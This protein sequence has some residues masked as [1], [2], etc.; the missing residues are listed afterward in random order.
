MK[1]LDFK[2][3]DGRNIYSHK[4]CIRMDLD[5]EGYSEIPSKDIN[6]FNK[7][8]VKI[9]PELKNH[10]CGDNEENGF[11]K[12][13]D[14]GTYLAHIC[15]HVTIAVQNMIGINVSYG[16]AREVFGD[17]YYIIYQFQYKNVGIEAGKTAVDIINSII[18]QKKF[19]MKTRIN[20]L[21][22]VL[23]NEMIG[24]STLSIINEAKKRGI[25]VTK[26]GDGS[27]FQLGYG[28]YSKIIEATITEDTSTVAVDIAC[29][30]VLC[31]E[32]LKRQ[33]LPVARG[34]KVNNTLDLLFKAD[35]I[36]YPVVLKPQFGNQG[37]GVF[38]NLNNEKAVV[39]AYCILSKKYNDIIIEKYI[40]G[41]DF[42]VC[43]IDGEVAAV[44]ERIPPFVIGNGINTIEELIECINRSPKRGEGHEK[45]LTKISIDEGLLSYIKKQ[46]YCLN[47]VL[48]DGTK[49]ILREN[50]NLSTGGSAVDCTELICEENIEICRRAAKAIGLNI[51]GIDIC[52]TD[53]S[54]PISDNGAIIEVNAAPG[55]RMHQFPSKG[56]TRDTASA[57]V[58]MLFKSEKNSV[59]VISISGTNGKTTTSRLIAHVL[60][61]AGYN[62]GMT[63]TG[64]IYINNK[65][66]QRGDTTGPMSALTVLTNKE[67]DAAVLETARGGIIR[68]GL[69]YDLADV[70][71]ITNITEDHLGIDGIENIED[72]A[73]VKALVAEA[74]KDQGYV[75]INADDRMSLSILNRIKSKIIFFTKDKNNVFLRESLK[76][77]GYGVYLEN[78]SIV[79]Q[80]KNEI[81]P[82]IKVDK[83]G[84][85]LG[86]KLI[87]N[88]ENAMAACASLIALGIDYSII[89]KGL[90][91]FSCNEECNPGRF[92]IYKFNNITVV[93]DYGHNIEGYRAVLEGIKTLKHK[94]LVG[95]IGV[96]GDRSDRSIIEIG[97]ISAKYFDYI[98]IKEDKDRRGRK[99]GEVAKLLER[100]ALS[101]DFH[102]KSIDIILSEK[103]AL[104]KAINV[105]KSGDIIII[106][107]ENYDEL[108]NIVK[109]KINEEVKTISDESMA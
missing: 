28:R 13:L 52:C 61:L 64:G 98:Y 91:S 7:E 71:I 47:T 103:E 93:L 2:V 4:S 104:S 76:Y 56:K 20:L 106:F 72:L 87:Y 27:L 29:D 67:I 33:C 86:G 84:I 96:P 109:D 108:V 14:E 94:R 12:R 18:S 41:K 79:I 24:P 55:I 89:Q 35:S 81:H 44:A 31:K 95:I 9:I 32:M 50:A 54:K 30:K 70:G 80:N 34:Y 48:D 17:V 21:N 25:P 19:N 42:R 77:V 59:P 69:A 105:A 43:V 65:C 101:E 73:D 8:L 37:K 5:L 45:I 107:F 58:D 22:E 51:C 10:H 15:E 100:G 26:I 74:V 78:N 36:G 60:A 6:G 82:L 16:K 85:T 40:K 23:K 1:I 3:F 102:S 57:V 83:I 62:V 63:T 68:A 92:N 88:V 11:I 46:G 75:V 38:T 66:I 49:V 99:A 39:S 90:I 53:I 97:K